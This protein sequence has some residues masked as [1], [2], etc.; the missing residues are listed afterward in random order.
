MKGLLCAIRFLTVFPAGRSCGDRQDEDIASCAVW[1]PVV[2][3]VTGCVLALSYDL[4]YCILPLP[5]VCVLVLVL[6]VVITGG[7]HA[8]GFIDTADAIASGADR[9]RM[10]EIM[11]EGRPGALGIAAA[12]LLFMSKFAF[13]LS[14]RPAA[15]GLSL[16]AMSV[17]GK[18]SFA[19][20]GF[21]YRY[22]R[23]GRGLG[24]SILGKVPGKSLVLSGILCT[25]IPALIF[26]FKIFIFFPLICS[27]FFIC[28]AWLSKRLGGLTGDT[29]GAVS[30]ILEGSTLLLAAVLA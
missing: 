15:A 3:L 20:S 1:F 28:N 12:I 19:V 8:D 4:L 14:L 25:C 2:G 21:F 24:G 27:V 10:L 30:E 26:G 18:S 16:V 23:Q 11:R 13:M 7:M 6:S 29:L 5:A 17:I 22:A 9:E